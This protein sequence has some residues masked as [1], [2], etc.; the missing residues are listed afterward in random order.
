[1]STQI[2]SLIS[3]PLFSDAYI[4]LSKID[5]SGQLV[6]SSRSVSLSSSRSRWPSL[7]LS[8]TRRRRAS[9]ASVSSLVDF[10]CDQSS[11]RVSV[12]VFVDK[13]LLPIVFESMHQAMAV[14]QPVK[15]IA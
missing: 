11:I 14:S 12:F 8:T 1:M 4:D 3:F 9:S 5:V 2:G 13:G 6:A 7:A 10:F 15:G